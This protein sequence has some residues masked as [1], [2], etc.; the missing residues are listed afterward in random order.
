M[1]TFVGIELVTA[2]YVQ[3]PLKQ[4]G[5]FPGRPWTVYYEGGTRA[6]GKRC[7]RGL[8]SFETQQDAAAF[9]ARLGWCAN[10]N[11]F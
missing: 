3:G 6:N 2:D 8:A 5:L 11:P 1:T 7:K 9:A 4:P 10:S